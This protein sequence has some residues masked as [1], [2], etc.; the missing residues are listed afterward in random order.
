MKTTIEWLEE[1]LKSRYILL[2]SEP[3]FEEAKRLHKSELSLAYNDGH[4]VGYWNAP[5]EDK[6][7]AAADCA[8]LSFK[9]WYNKTYKK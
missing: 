3:I 5:S 6:S 2:N 1:E 4:S 9:E 7:S 8:D